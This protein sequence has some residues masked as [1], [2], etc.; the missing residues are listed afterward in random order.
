MA[1]ERRQVVECSEM[2]ALAGAVPAVAEAVA[3]LQQFEQ[4]VALETDRA[5][6]GWED[7]DPEEPV[8]ARVDVLAEVAR[9]VNQA[10]DAASQAGR[11]AEFYDTAFADVPVAP[12]VWRC[13]LCTEQVSSF[14]T[15]FSIYFKYTPSQYLL[16]VYTCIHIC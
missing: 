8:P 9:C 3:A 6:N 4:L 11:L 5:T 1:V 15:T 14:T 12:A 16:Y 10:R 13:R 7:W 2:P